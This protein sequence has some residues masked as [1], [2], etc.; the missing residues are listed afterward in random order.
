M[1]GVTGAQTRTLKIE[2]KGGA[3]DI[4]VSPDVPIITLVTADSSLL[5]PGATVAVIATQKDGSLIATRLIAEKDGFKP[6]E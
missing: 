2:Y 6:Q 5:K 4:E 3:Q 1:S